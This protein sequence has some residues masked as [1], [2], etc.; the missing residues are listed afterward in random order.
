M[1]HILRLLL[2]AVIL[3]GSSEKTAATEEAWRNKSQ[4]WREQ[5]FS[6]TLQE[7]AKYG[8]ATQVLIE[9]QLENKYCLFLFTLFD[10]EEPETKQQI[11]NPYERPCN[12]CSTSFVRRSNPILLQ[13][14]KNSDVSKSISQKTLPD[15][16]IDN[17]I[18][19]SICDLYTLEDPINMIRRKIPVVPYQQKLLRECMTELAQFPSI[20][21]LNNSSK[22][23][24]K[25][26]L[27]SIFKKA[28]ISES[29]IKRLFEY[30]KRPDVLGKLYANE[31][32]QRLNLALK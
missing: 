26:Y 13:R 1:N 16:I 20:D 25:S 2:A 29:S 27:W 10:S 21:K 15:F 12:K 19:A 7:R 11:G 18:S 4:S 3:I 8:Y 30:L 31:A 24:L 23:E 22:M 17:I 14:F 32:V 28:Y 6:W 5:V 9:K